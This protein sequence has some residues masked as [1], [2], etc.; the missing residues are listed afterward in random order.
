MN[1]IS[2][3]TRGVGMFMHEAHHKDYMQINFDHR[4]VYH[5]NLYKISNIPSFEL[6]SI[7][8]KIVLFWGGGDIPTPSLIRWFNAFQN[9]LQFFY[10][11]SRDRTGHGHM[12][13]DIVEDASHL[14]DP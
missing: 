4:C 11:N 2:A 14:K 1:I 6:Y 8:S 3:K 12:V 7:F 9:L 13:E 10:I 5:Y